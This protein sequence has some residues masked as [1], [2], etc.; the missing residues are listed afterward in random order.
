MEGSKEKAFGNLNREIY[1]NEPEENI[2]KWECCNAA[3]L[4]E[5]PF[6]DVFSVVVPENVIGQEKENT[7]IYYDRKSSKDIDISFVNDESKLQQES[8]KEKEVQESVNF[9]EEHNQVCGNNS[10]DV[11]GTRNYELQKEQKNETDSAKKFQREW[12][13]FNNEKKM[14]FSMK[15]KINTVTDFKVMKM[16]FH[17]KGNENHWSSKTDFCSSI[18]LGLIFT[19]CPTLIAMVLNYRVAYEFVYGSYYTKRGL[20]EFLESFLELNCKR[21][22]I[23]QVQCLDYD[24]IWGLLTIAL[25]FV[26]GFFWS[27]GFFIQFGTFLRKVYPRCFQRKGM[28][29][30]FFIPF[31]LLSMVTFPFQLVTVGI[32]SCFN[33]Q[34]QWK[35]LMT[36]MEIADGMFHA[37]LQYMLQIFIFFTRADTYPSLFQ[38]LA[39]FGSLLGLVW[40]RLKSFLLDRAGHSMSPGQRA[41]WIIRYG[42]FFLTCSAYKVASISLI[43]SMLRYNSIWLYGTCFVGWV[44]IQLLFNE[45]CLPLRYYHL[46]LGAGLHAMSSAHISDNI[47]IIETH[48]HCRDNILWSTRLSSKQLHC[49]LFFQNAFWFLF[50]LT[51]IGSLVVV[52]I[53]YPN[54]KIPV[55]WPLNMELFTLDRKK[56]SG[57]LLPYSSFILILGFISVVLAWNLTRKDEEEEGVNFVEP[58]VAKFE[59]WIHDSDTCQGCLKGEEWHEHKG[60]KDLQDG[61][62][63]KLGHIIAPLVNIWQNFVDKNTSS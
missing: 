10:R 3:Q 55:F 37:H 38:Y 23:G 54:I 21:T 24:P 27:L 5:E 14:R 48:K 44:I 45:R 28:I 34:D 60:D 12:E 58:K 18:V 41:W 33:T 36:K 13:R 61:V 49:N 32:I 63:G 17:S 51:V 29:I 47:K 30:C 11:L 22:P 57:I 43:I 25:T 46:F 7:A 4:N 19:V 2:E 31:G 15:K 53:L 40:S 16:E 26:P 1:E 8:S 50:N 52:C 39:A 6:G 9:D 42:P 56:I 35:L 59:G 20:F 62:Q